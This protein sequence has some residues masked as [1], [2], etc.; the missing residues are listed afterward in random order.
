MPIGFVS[1]RHSHYFYET[2]IY[3]MKLNMFEK[4]VNNLKEKQECH[5][6]SYQINKCPDG[7]FCNLLDSRIRRED[8][9]Y[10]VSAEKFTGFCAFCSYDKEGKSIC[11]FSH[12]RVIFSDCLN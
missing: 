3:F 8:V 4:D 11:D 7:Q 2:N 5:L 9:I 10:D 6:N 12:G 1:Q